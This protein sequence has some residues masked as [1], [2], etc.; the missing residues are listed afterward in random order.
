MIQDNKHVTEEGILKIIKIKQS[1]NFRNSKEEY[2]Y[3]SKIKS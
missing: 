3:K 1:M 2:N